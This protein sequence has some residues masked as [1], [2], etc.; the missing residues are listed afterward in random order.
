MKFRLFSLFVLVLWF[1]LFA[2]ETFRI[3]SYNALKFPDNSGTK[4]LPYFKTVID[5]LDPDILVLQEIT[6][7]SGVDFFLNDILNAEEPFLYTAAPFQDGPDTDN[8]LFFKSRRFSLASSRQIRTSLRD[9]SEY[10]LQVRIKSNMP[11]IWL[12]S[13]HLKA[14]DDPDEAQRRANDATLWRAQLNKLPE[15]THFFVMGDLNF[16]SHTEQGFKILTRDDGTTGQCF[17]PA[18]KVGE[19]HNNRTYAK[20]H[21]QSTRTTSLYDGSTGGMDDRFDFI[22]VSKALMDKREYYAPAENYMAFGN[23]GFHF[24]ANIN[25]G[26]NAVVS[27]AVANALYQASDHLPVVLDVVWNSTNA[28]QENSKAIDTFELAN[29]PNPF[30]SRTTIT[31]TVPQPSNVRV[32]IYDMKGQHVESVVNQFM[33][34][35]ASSFSWNAEELQSGVYFCKIQT[36]HLMETRKL[37]FMK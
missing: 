7:K 3:V 13:T 33:V 5:A 12:Y 28:V 24:N 2:Q 9:I 17:D 8:T 36:S 15:G 11:S 6:N 30:N 16:Y 29:F 14:G 19:W 34:A 26:T 18:N 22:L 20:Y 21:T 4:R 1:Q 31:F 23:D 25:D 27:K 10:E 35:G 32:D 37:L